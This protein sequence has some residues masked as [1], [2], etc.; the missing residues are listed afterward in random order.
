LRNWPENPR[1]AEAVFPPKN[2]RIRNGV[3]HTFPVTKIRAELHHIQQE[4]PRKLR[5]SL[6][7]MGILGRNNCRNSP[8]M[9]GNTAEKY[10]F[11]QQY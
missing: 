3:F 11:P 5:K 7:K 2:H 8:D 9:L 4:K 6:V 10:R 1:K